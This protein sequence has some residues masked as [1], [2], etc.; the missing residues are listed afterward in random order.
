MPTDGYLNFDTKL[1][2]SGFENGSEKID[3]EAKKTADSVAKEVEKAAEKAKSAIDSVDGSKVNVDVEVDSE[4]GA[5]AASE[6]VRETAS[7]AQ[8]ASADAKAAIQDILAD[9]ELTAQEKAVKIAEVYREQGDDMSTAMRKAMSSINAAAEGSNK[10]VV[11][12]EKKLSTEL[13]SIFSGIES[14]FKKAFKRSGDSAY[15]SVNDLSSK[16]KPLF[17]KI[18]AAAAAAF[19]VRTLA[20]YAKAAQEAYTAQL[21]AET[22][23]G[24]VM[25]HALGATQEQIQA[26]KEWSSELQKTGVIG[27]EIQLAGLQEL[28]TY[29][30]NADS[31]KKMNVVLN[32]M[33]A[34]QYGYNATADSAVTISTMLG[35]VLEGQTSALSRYGYSFTD[36]QERLLKYGTEEQKVATLAEVV[37]ASVG[38]M[39]E[40]LAK[41]PTGRLK[42]LSNTMGDIK[43]QFGQATTNVKSL[44]VPALERLAAQLARIAELAVRASEAIASVFGISLD[45]SAAVAGN[46]SDSVAAQEDLTD[47]VEETVKAQNKSLAGFDK[48]NTLSSQTAQEA[49]TGAGSSSSYLS[50]DIDETP[51]EK[52]LDS[53]S[54]KLKELAEPVKI[55]WE[56]NGDTLISSAKYAVDS[57]K[58]LIGSIGDSLEEVWTN[59]SGERFVGNIITLFGDV[60]GIIGDIAAALKNAW[61]DD[62]RGTALIQS[63]YDKLNELLE[64]IH[65]IADSFR[66]SWNDGHGVAI[67]S[68]Y[69][70]ISTGINNIWKNLFLNVKKTWKKYGKRIFDDIFTVAEN[71]LGTISDIIDDTANW[72]KKVDLSPLAEA[73]AEL[74]EALDP[75]TGAVGE[76]LEW[77]YN[78]VLL[79]L[80]GWVLKEAVPRG[81]GILKG[82]IQTLTALIEGAEPTLKYLWEDFLKPLGEWT[83]E[84]VT[85]ELDELEESLEKIAAFARDNPDLATYLAA[86]GVGVAVGGAKGAAVVSIAEIIAQI[87]AIRENWD[88]IKSV[89][90]EDGGFFKFTHNWLGELFA[91]KIEGTFLEEP[92]KA[93]VQFGKDWDDFWGNIGATVGTW[94]EKIAKKLVKFGEDW[95][96]FWGVT[97]VDALWNA[98]GKVGSVLSSVVGF[99]KNAL[100]KIKET[101]AGIGEWFGK[102]AGAIKT[103]F[104]DMPAWF[105]EKFDDAWNKI[106]SAF[107][108]IGEWFGEKSGTIKTTFAGMPA[109]FK[110]KF[111]DVWDKIKSAF[112]G[113]GEFFGKKSG[114]VKSPFG[115]IG[116]WFKEK[117]DTVYDKI[118]EAF[119]GLKG[120]FSGLWTDIKVAARD[121]LNGLIDMVEQ[122][123]NY[124][125]SGALTLASKVGVDLPIDYIHIPRIP[126]LAT[127]TV[128]PANYGRFLA[129]LGDNKRETEVVSPLSTIEQ[130]VANALQ[131]HGGGGES[132]IHVHVDLDGR[133]IGKVAVKAVNNDN[134]RKGK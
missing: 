130:A 117:F 107:S 2:T 29:L 128:I 129:M 85:E 69:L 4:R 82:A 113:V 18:S 68:K 92:A 40:A 76:G 30:E 95:D 133:E 121:A 51:V 17:G 41:T 5:A 9:T 72:A 55:A 93:M 49:S 46:I 8:E 79:P 122:T 114:E 26:T 65:T 103:V 100:K 109:W 127:G 44:F 94:I 84:I 43:E 38:G 106:K 58:G 21:E 89:M 86:L 1:N 83:G 42:Q 23:L 132:V 22:K 134:A 102:K 77:F 87:A 78:N 124:P 28:A 67:I 115:S 123:I 75:F 120:F 91:G 47:A 14:A 37:E 90:E 59:G 99:F 71:I 33:L 112:S 74:L 96:N 3:D 48:I 119:S 39:N 52:K 20:N 111:G 98:A 66:E 61:E 116:G 70:E 105:K 101:F 81:L 7:A 56:L 104:A 125:I 24:Q 57:I 63:H 118:T 32:D 10:K 80:A 60:L 64:L 31:L 54:E 16:L 19:S 110:E 12:S 6:A 97:V 53:I 62:G 45:N 25:S 73:T 35:K 11:R 88:D 131:K 50:V 15:K 34:Q 108:G 13:K 36:A 27:D 126:A